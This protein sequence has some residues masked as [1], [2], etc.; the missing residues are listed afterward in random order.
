MRRRRLIAIGV[1]IALSCGALAGYWLWLPA[2]PPTSQVPQVTIRVVGH[3]WYWEFFVTDEAGQTSHTFGEAT[4]QVGS[5]VNLIVTSA[6]IVYAFYIP[7]L[8][9]KLDVIPGHENT[10]SFAAPPVGDYAVKNAEFGEGSYLMVAT[11]QVVP[12]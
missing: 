5:Q 6:D 3:Q 11:L 8:S 4:V 1:I 7:E 12:A 10:F 2:A 9:L